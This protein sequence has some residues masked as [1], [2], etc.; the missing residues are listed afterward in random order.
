MYFRTAF[1]PG[2]PK[3]YEA[4]VNSSHTDPVR[5]GSLYSFHKIFEQ[6]IPR[7]RVGHAAHHRAGQPHHHQS[8]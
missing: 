8:E 5:T 3:G 4:Q 1:G 6:L 7:R 2:F